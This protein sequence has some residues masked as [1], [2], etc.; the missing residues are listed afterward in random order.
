LQAN[1]KEADERTLIEAAQRDPARFAD[2][3]ENHFNRVYAYIATR[4]RNRD[5]AQDLTSEVFHQALANLRRF[6]W[7]GVPFSAWLLRIAANAIADRWQKTARERG[8]P[9]PEKLEEVHWEDIEERARLFELVDHLPAD[10]RHVIL[11]RFV[12]QKS[13]REIAQQLQRTEGAVK[14]LQ[15]RAIQ[16]LRTRMG[17]ANG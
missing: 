6:E 15:F 13:I 1:S 10:Q 5:E 3:Y 2:L 11:E 17:E 14:Q 7:R 12:E 8:N 16:N 9:T 4:V